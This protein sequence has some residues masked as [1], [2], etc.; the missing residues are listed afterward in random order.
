GGVVLDDSTPRREGGPRRQCSRR[1]RAMSG[2]KVHVDGA[3][4]IVGAHQLDLFGAPQIGE[5]EYTKLAES[6]HAAHR[7]RI[8]RVNQPGG[9]RHWGEVAAIHV[10]LSS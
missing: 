10:R 2:G 6:D 7:L 5:I 9:P 8:I 1:N 3:N 4:R